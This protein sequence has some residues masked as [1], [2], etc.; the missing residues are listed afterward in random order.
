MLTPPAQR[1]TVET[2]IAYYLVSVLLVVTLHS[3]ISRLGHSTDLELLVLPVFDY[4]AP[5]ASESL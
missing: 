5:S 1:A 3:T 4:V 2:H